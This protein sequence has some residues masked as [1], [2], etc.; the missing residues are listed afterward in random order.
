VYGQPG[1][2]YDERLEEENAFF[3]SVHSGKN[4]LVLSF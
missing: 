4:I 2:E 3:A 1:N